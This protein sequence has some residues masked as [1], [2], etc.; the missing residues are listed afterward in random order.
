MKSQDVHSL[1][2]VSCSPWHCKTAIGWPKLSRAFYIQLMSPSIF[3][4]F[5]PP[6]SFHMCAYTWAITDR[7][8]SWIALVKKKIRLKIRWVLWALLTGIKCTAVLLVSHTPLTSFPLS[9][10]FS[11]FWPTKKCHI[12]RKMINWSAGTG[13][14]ACYSPMLHDI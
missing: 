5:P 6:L 1:F 8:H 3:K 4:D 9:G 11:M 13:V 12:I 7:G 2:H 14:S 10:C